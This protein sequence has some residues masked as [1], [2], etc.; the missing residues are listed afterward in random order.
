MAYKELMDQGIDPNAD[1]ADLQF[2][3][4]HDNV[5]YAVQNGEVDAGTVRTD[6]LERMHAAG[7]IDMGEFKILNARQNDA[8]P[9]VVSTALY[10]EWPFAKTAATA[11]ETARQVAA[12]LFEMANDSAAAKAA[13][14][15]GWTQPL[16]YQ[17]VDALQQ[18][19]GIG[20]Y[21]K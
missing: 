13:K 1:F 19:L 8:F 18:S 6:T 2:G 10:P 11:P 12:A 7:D 3:N 17:P 5:V 15:V 21:Q 16:D 20:A 9:F 14:I 4:K